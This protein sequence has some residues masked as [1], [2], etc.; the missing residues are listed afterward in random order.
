MIYEFSD[1]LEQP[2]KVFTRQDFVGLKQVVQG[3]KHP[4]DGMNGGMKEGS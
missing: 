3:I 2:M 1:V 4:N